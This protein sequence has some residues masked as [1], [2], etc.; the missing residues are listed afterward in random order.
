MEQVNSEVKVQW[1]YDLQNRKPTKVESNFTLGFPD[2][3]RY[4]VVLPMGI[5]LLMLKR[6]S[7]KLY[8]LF[9]MPRKIRSTVR[10]ALERGKHGLSCQLFCGHRLYRVHLSCLNCRI[11]KI[12]QKKMKPLYPISSWHIITIRA[13]RRFARARDLLIKPL[14]SLIEFLAS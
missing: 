10:S 5:R 12:L 13:D 14:A 11:R 3:G 7:G 4:D 8:E 9:L 6:D 2:G 1:T